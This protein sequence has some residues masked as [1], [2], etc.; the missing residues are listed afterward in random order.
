MPYPLGEEHDHSVLIPLYVIFKFL[1]TKYSRL[2]QIPKNT[3]ERS[4]DTLI[5]PE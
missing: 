5:L 2:K 4:T 3:S 1:L